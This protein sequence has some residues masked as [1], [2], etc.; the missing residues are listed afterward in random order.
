MNPLLYTQELRTFGYIPFMDLFW[1]EKVLSL[2][3][4]VLNYDQ[5]PP[6]DTHAQRGRCYLPFMNKAVWAK[7]FK[8]KMKDIFFTYSLSNH[9]LESTSC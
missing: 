8:S 2:G 6:S 1:K 5:Y 9:A 7:I 3:L 4:F